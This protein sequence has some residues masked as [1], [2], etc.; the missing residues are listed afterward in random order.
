[1]RPVSEIRKNAQSYPALQRCFIDCFPGS[2]FTVLRSVIGLENLHHLSRYQMQNLN[3][4]QPSH[5]RFPALQANSES[6]VPLKIFLLFFF[7]FSAAVI[8]LDKSH[9]NK[10]R[11]ALY[12]LRSAARAFGLLK[13]TL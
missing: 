12:Q 13:V 9:D 6:L 2:G 1:M 8:L 3:Q 5:S 11:R 7:F 4:S 10:S